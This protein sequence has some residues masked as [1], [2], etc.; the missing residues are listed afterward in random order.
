M[1][2]NYNTT[3]TFSKGK[4]PEGDSARKVAAPFLKEKAVMSIYNGPVPHE[5]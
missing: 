5:S 1:M 2:K 4:K 3:G